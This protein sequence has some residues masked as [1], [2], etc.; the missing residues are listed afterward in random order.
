[1]SKDC[2][3]GTYGSPESDKQSFLLDSVDKKYIK[4][5]GNDYNLIEQY[6]SN[7]IINILIAIRNVHNLKY[8]KNYR[9]RALKKYSNANIIIKIIDFD[10]LH[11]VK[12]YEFKGIKYKV[13]CFDY[14]NPV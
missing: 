5:S 10:E 12:D 13:I 8:A 6:L 2:I 9:A 3:P 11:N 7:K 4:N 1:M 14:F